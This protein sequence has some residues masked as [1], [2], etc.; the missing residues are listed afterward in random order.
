MC[1]VNSDPVIGNG[2]REPTRFPASLKFDIDRTRGRVCVTGNVG[3]SL[4]NDCNRIVA[5]RIVNARIEQF[6]AVIFAF[7]L[8]VDRLAVDRNE[9]RRCK[10]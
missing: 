8:F 6:N 7:F 5:S 4:A 9:E 1:G 10:A 3:Q 2:N